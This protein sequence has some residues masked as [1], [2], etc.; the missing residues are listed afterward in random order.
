MSNVINYWDK[1]TAWEK[2]V[3]RVVAS[4][5]G[6]MRGRPGAQLQA[7][8]SHVKTW[9]PPWSGRGSAPAP[10]VLVDTRPLGARTTK[11]KAEAGSV[12]GCGAAMAAPVGGR[13]GIPHQ[14]RI[15]RDPSPTMRAAVKSRSRVSNP[16]FLY[17]SDPHYLPSIGIFCLLE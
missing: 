6:D 17:P 14:I 5:L 12:H 7:S 1:D 8:P 15:R 2:N 13:L 3:D 4:L 11:V 16:L 9:R 10:V